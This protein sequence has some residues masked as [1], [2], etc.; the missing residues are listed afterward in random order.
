MSSNGGFK[1][2]L[3]LGVHPKIKG[4]YTEVNL[5]VHARDRML[6]RSVTEQQ[7][8]DVLEK[9]DGSKSGHPSHRT[10]EWKRIKG[11][12][13]YVIWEQEPKFPHRL[14]VITTYKK[15]RSRRIMPK[16]RAKKA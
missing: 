2:S 6:E 15:Q 13:I 9:P 1:D 8:I 16:R 4:V 3:I 7:I 12:D 5:T 10:V 14:A 11:D